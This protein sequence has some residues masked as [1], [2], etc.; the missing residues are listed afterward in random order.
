MQKPFLLAL[1][2]FGFAA[3]PALSATRVA[4]ADEYFGRLNLSVLG[5]ANTIKDMRLRVEADRSKSLSIFGS[6]E[7]VVWSA[8]AGFH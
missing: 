7:F 4:P 2:L 6:L 1:A 5:I 8:C 3:G